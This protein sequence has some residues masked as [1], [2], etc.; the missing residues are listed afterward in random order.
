[1]VL[2]FAHHC[3]GI[4]SVMILQSVFPFSQKQSASVKQF[5][6]RFYPGVNYSYIFALRREGSDKDMNFL[7]QVFQEWMVWGVIASSRPRPNMAGA[8]L[9]PITP[10]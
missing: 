8:V 5:L 2:D 1:M 3:L 9:G 10:N 6:G 4:I 7:I